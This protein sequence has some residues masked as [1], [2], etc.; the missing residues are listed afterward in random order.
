[1][2]STNAS[3]WRQAK[4]YLVGGVN[5]P[6]RSFKSVGAG[7]FFV[8]RGAGPCLWDVEG[9]KLLDYVGSW[10]ALILGH[11]HPAVLRAVQKG[12]KRGITFGT[13]TPGETALAREISRAMPA[14]EQIRFVSSGTEAVMSAIRLARAATGRSKILKFDG[15]YHGHADALLARAGSGM[16]TL[17]IPASP[18]VPRRVTEDT[19]TASFNDLEGVERTIRRHG[20]TLACVIVEPVMANAGV[21]PPAPGFLKGLRA[22]TAKHGILLIFDE[23]ITGF[24]VGY[25]GAQGL[26]GVRPDLTTLGKVIGGGFAIGAYGGPARLM[27]LVA[28]RGKVYQAGT[29]AGHPI[30]MA[31]GLATLRVL[32]QPKRYGRLNDAGRE[33]AQGLR[34][35]SSQAGVPVVVNQAGSLVTLFFKSGSVCSAA[36]ARRADPRRYARYFR[37]MLSQ[38]VYLP[39][40]PFEAW[41]LSTAHGKR[42]IETTLKAHQETISEL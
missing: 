32:R 13:P 12:L 36:D 14:I 4:R 22:L 5:S 37:G 26:F 19:L 28:P 27:R 6:V 21:I 34:A 40:S 41:F 42:E 33:L 30:A 17:G 16:A 18:G 20:K 23:V 7:P 25:S 3:C 31:A 39:P 8:D 24:R 15:G 35:V 38:G 9:R 11:R 29:L 1:M 2:K 10:G